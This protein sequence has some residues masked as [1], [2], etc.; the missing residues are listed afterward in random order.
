MSNHLF[1]FKQHHQASKTWA[2]VTATNICSSSNDTSPKL[3]QECKCLPEVIISLMQSEE[4]VEEDLA[5]IKEKLDILKL[6]IRFRKNKLQQKVK[7]YKIVQLHC[8][9]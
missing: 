4:D 5:G 2:E 1:S 9:E 7:Y 3:E 6:Q 8:S